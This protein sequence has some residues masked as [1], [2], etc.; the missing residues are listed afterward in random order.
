MFGG[1]SKV[2]AFCVCN[3]FELKKD[4]I[5][6]IFIFVWLYLYFFEILN[7]RLIIIIIDNHAVHQ[8]ASTFD[9]CKIFLFLAGKVHVYHWGP[10]FILTP[11][12]KAKAG[13]HRLI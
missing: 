10:A 4:S 1:I 9:C 3:K 5:R 12:P 7:I 2:P 8:S 11:P 6:N 13:S